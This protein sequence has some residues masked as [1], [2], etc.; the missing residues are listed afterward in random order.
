VAVSSWLMNLS[1]MSQL[2]LS[3]V[4]IV[5]VFLSLLLQF[6]VH[7]LIKHGR[8]MEFWQKHGILLMNLSLDSPNRFRLMFRWWVSDTPAQMPFPAQE[9]A[10][11]WKV[12][13]LRLISWGYAY[14]LRAYSYMTPG[15]E[16]IVLGFI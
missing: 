4:R 9:I 7:V 2:W 1:L 13:L 8:S 14:L 10:L 11:W 15:K 16:P 3:F 12:G 5:W 6:Q